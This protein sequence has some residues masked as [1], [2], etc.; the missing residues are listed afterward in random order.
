MYSLAGQALIVVYRGSGVLNFA[1]GATGMS[2]AYVAWDLQ[3]NH[4][5]PFAFAFLAGTAFAAAVGVL[6]Q[7]LVIARLHRAS[8]L[9][10]IIATLGVLFTLEAAVTLR[11]GSQAKFMPNELPT[12]VWHLTHSTVLAENR[13]I[14]VGIALAMTVLLATV[15]RRTRFGLATTAVAESEAIASGFGLSP[16][17]IAA[18]NWGVGSAIIGAASI[19]IAPIISLQIGT[20]TTITLAA[21]AGTLLARMRS[22]W[23]VFAAGMAI[24]IL[25][26]ELNRF[27]DQ[28]G[29]GNAVPFLV[30]IAVLTVTGQGLPLRDFLLQRLPS[31]GPGEVRWV[32]ALVALAVAA[33]VILTVPT[34]WTAAIIISLSTAVVLLSIVVLTG[35]TGQ[36]SLAQFGLA[37]FGALVAGRLADAHGLPFWL[38]L[39]V[40]ACVAVPVGLLFAI[41]AV[42]TRGI[43]LAIVTLG[44]GTALEIVVFDNSQFTGKELGTNT[45][46]ATIFGWDVGAIAHPA[47]FALVVL[48]V[49]ALCTFFVA[50]LRRGVTGRTLIAVRTNE[51]AAAAMGIHVAGAKLY[52]F[53]LAAGI[54]GVGGVLLA[55]STQYVDYT[56]FSSNQSVYLVGLALIGGVGYLIGPLLASQIVA[57]GI[58][59]QLLN[60]LGLSGGKYIPLIGGIGI[61]VLV[62][63]NPDGQVKA[64]SHQ[65]RWI[66]Q[67]LTRRAPDG[68]AVLSI[69]SLTN[70]HETV[71][72]ARSLAVRDVTVRYGGITAVDS[73]SLDIQPGKILGLI[74]PNGAGKSTLIDAITGFVTLSDGSILLDEHDVSRWTATR[75]AREGIARSFQS[76]ELFEDSTVL[77]N[78]RVA[79]DRRDWRTFLRDLV[80]PGRAELPSSVLAVVRQFGFENELDVAVQ[81]LPYGKRRLLAIARA[82]VQNPSI[83]LL[84]EPGAGLSEREL[85]ELA[86]LIRR[87]VA[88]RNLAVLVVEHDINFVMSLC[89]HIVVLDF[90]RKIAEGDPAS[91]Q[92]NA[93]VMEAYLGQDHQA[94]LSSDAEGEALERTAT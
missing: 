25:E 73:V 15:Y 12:R 59:S 28:Q 37:G 85:L 78:L 74:G 84:D 47:R 24:A 11:Y 23:I 82:A 4:G 31:V 57:G 17:R 14:L 71:P 72:V 46:P 66:K 21:L 65:A 41:P 38:A 86:A 19:L 44:L 79:A 7:V 54:A 43:N 91:V 61:I 80:R 69:E 55:Y 13:V 88:E 87:L 93:A 68:Y 40:G 36:L 27:V 49:L 50:N 29:I 32:P 8:P 30:I 63:Q 3:V 76:L 35:Y 81:D 45:G 75:R 62:L 52:A 90:G 1:L 56:A 58:G 34:S 9:V 2:G 89:D 60:S 33:L 39:P 51:R 6:T 53:G 94:D 5:V 48:V 18:V 92:S 26:T 67:K 42:R 64:I 83:L 10:R 22:F 16:G 20:M 77:E 70:V